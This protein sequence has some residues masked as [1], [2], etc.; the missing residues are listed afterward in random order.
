MEFIGTAAGLPLRAGLH[1]A[2]H[3]DRVRLEGALAPRRVAHL[4]GLHPARGPQDLGG[5]AI[6]RGPDVVGP[7]GLLRSFADLLKFVLKEPVI[8]AGADKVVF[9]LAPLITSILAHVGLG[10]G[11]DRRRDGRWPTSTSASSISLRSDRSASTASSWA[12][13]RPTISTVS[14]ARSVQPR[15]WCR[16]EVS[17]GFVII[18]VLLCVGSLN[19]SDIVVAQNE[20]GPRLSPRRAVALD[21]QLVLAAALPDVRRC[22]SS[23]P[24]PRR[25]GRPSTCQKRSRNS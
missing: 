4:H 21:P 8:P 5:G 3:A 6:R 19:L 11:A 17:I 10:R 18:T 22:F 15:R 20:H 1:R 25:T 24:W 9:L 23:R 2:R 12:G 13:G 16:Y 7:F 14:S